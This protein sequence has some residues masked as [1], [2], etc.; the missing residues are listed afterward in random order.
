MD[1][2]GSMAFLATS[3]SGSRRTATSHWYSADD[4]RF[5]ACY[6]CAFDVAQATSRRVRHV[7]TLTIAASDECGFDMLLAELRM[8]K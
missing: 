6:E 7:Y 4:C 8:R 2:T 5:H 1:A 3:I